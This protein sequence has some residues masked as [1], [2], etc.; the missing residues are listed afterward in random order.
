MTNKLKYF[1]GNWKMF[2]DFGDFKIIHK[3]NQFGYESGRLLKKKKIEFL[4]MKFNW[5]LRA[6]DLEKKSVPFAIAT[7]I[8]TVAPSSA[9]PTAKAII[10]IDGKMDGWIG[11]GC[12]QETVIEEALVNNIPVLLFGGK[13]RYSHFKINNFTPDLKQTWHKPSKTDQRCLDRLELK[14]KVFF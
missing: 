11:G 2:G 7:V 3:I 6:A 1:I 4:F 14:D 8:D 12:A 10:T 13:G 5:I 9:K